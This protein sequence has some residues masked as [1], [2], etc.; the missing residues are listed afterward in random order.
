MKIV[1]LKTG[2][3]IEYLL[4]LMFAMETAVM[5]EVVSAFLAE[6]IMRKFL[7]DFTVK[8]CSQ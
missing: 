5:D 2:E 8:S 7:S 4:K 3:E 1:D 6:Q